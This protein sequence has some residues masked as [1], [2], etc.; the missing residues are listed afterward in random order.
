MPIRTVQIQGQGYGSTPAQITVTAR[1]NTVFSGTV[2][3]VNQ[4][5]LSL[6]NAEI[7]LTNVLCTFEIDTAF[8]GEIPMT[9]AVSAG[10]VIFSN[11]YANY[12]QIPNPVYTLAQRRTV[13]SPDTTQAD[14]VA[15]YTQV[16]VPALS[17]AD[18]DILMDPATTPEQYNAIV[19]AHN[20][21]T[22]IPS[23]AS[24]YGPIVNTDPRNSVVINGTP[25]TPD[26]GEL[27]GA[28][29]WTINAGSTMTYQLTVDP[30]KV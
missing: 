6:P 30:A 15:M 19:V 13:I 11:I 24:G 25:Q 22:H 16:A 29:W 21:T 26:H 4:P 1:G 28:W 8:V 10:T 23:G 3:T 20:C 27:A 18:I 12:V 9:C 5:V 2:D 17:Q 14:R 7:N